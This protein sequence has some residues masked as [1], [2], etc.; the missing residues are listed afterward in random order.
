M[1]IEDFTGLSKPTRLST[2]L[3]RR[4]PGWLAAEG[5]PSRPEGR[6]PRPGPPRVRSRR[7]AAG[8]LDWL[9]ALP[10]L[11]LAAMMLVAP[12]I[13]L[14]VGSFGIP[15]TLDAR[16]LAR[17]VPEQWRSER[18]SDQRPTWARDAPRSR[19]SSAA[20]SPG[21]FR[22]WSLPGARSGWRCSTSRPILAASGWPSATW[23]RSAP[24]AWS[25]SRC[26][27]SASPGYPPEI[28]SF[29]SLVMAYEYTNIPLFVLLTLPAMGILRQE[30]LEAAEVCA[31]SRWQ[32]WR[33]VGSAGADALPGRRLSARSSPG[34]S[35]STVSPTRW[36]APRPRPGNCA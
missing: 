32:F 10:L 18:D 21:S 9:P 27:T 28:G 2:A 31:A 14:I 30:W 1:V 3:G 15:R 33:Y 20:R 7:S 8:W 35:A 13:A 4:G 11:V 25:R 34:R 5:S 22:G 17:H 29:T 12:T 26:R 23:R 16:L 6:R 19:S 36:A 24:S